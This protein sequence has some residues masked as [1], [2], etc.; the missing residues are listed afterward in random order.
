MQQNS[1]YRKDFPFFDNTQCV[2]L[3]NGAT[4]QKPLCVIEAEGHYY[5]ELNA[6]VHRGNHPLGRKVTELYEQARKKIAA[7]VNV[8]ANEVVFTKGTTESINLVAYGLSELITS[9]DT[10]AITALEHHANIVPWQELCKRTGAKLVVLPLDNNHILDL[11][12]AIELINYHR[13]KVLAVAHISNVLGSI[14][15]IEIL[16][17]TAKQYPNYT[18]VDGAQAMLHTAPD[19]AQ[20]PCDFYVFSAHKMFGPTGVGILIGRYERLCELSVFQTGGEMI[21]DVSFE[22]STYR[23]PPAKFETGTPNIAGIIAYSAAIDY[24]NELDAAA[25]TKYE[26]ELFSYLKQELQSIP[27]V[28]TYGDLSNNH[29]TV[30]FN[31]IGEHCF[32]VAQLLSEQNIAIRSGHHCAQPLHSVL[33]VAGTLRVSL[34][35]YNN[36]QDVDQFIKALKQAIELLTL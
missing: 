12:K 32:D 36:K 13:P 6:N 34:A 15:P 22:R 11:P 29:G 27:N 20:L 1:I 23:L 2:Y 7:Y 31:V 19:L 25:V 16:I 4:S 10:I 9:Q 8:A 24:L 26:R 30:A 35:L 17:K 5:N 21:E 18:L 3:D 33:N 14:Q 28:E